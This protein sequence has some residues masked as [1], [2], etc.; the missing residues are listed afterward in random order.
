[1]YL[2]YASHARCPGVGASI[3]SFAWGW[4][5]RPN[6]LKFIMTNRLEESNL[7]KNYTCQ[8]LENVYFN[9]IY[10]ATCEGGFQKSI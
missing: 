6:M 3:R 10:R 4:S 9:F 7:N 2:Y 5:I 1:M 8:F